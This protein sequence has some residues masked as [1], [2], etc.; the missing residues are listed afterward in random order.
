MEREVGV[1][2][3]VRTLDDLFQSPGRYLIP[4]FQRPYVWDEEHQWNLLWDDIERTAEG[5]FE[6]G[7]SP[8]PEHFLGAIVLQQQLTPPGALVARRVIDGQQRLIT[9]QLLL[10]A[11]EFALT[12]LDESVERFATRIRGLTR[13]ASAYA[14]PSQ[15]ETSLKVLPT[16]AD[17]AAFQHAMTRTELAG[18]DDTEDL[19]DIEWAHEFF[20]DQIAEWL[21]R[22]PDRITQRAAALDITLRAKLKVV[23]IDLDH[24]DDPNVIFEALNARGT[25]LLAWDLTKNH[26]L[27]AETRAGRDDER[28]YADHLKAIEEDSWWREDVR[29]GRLYVPRIDAFLFYWLVV[30]TQELVPADAVFKIFQEHARGQGTRDVAADLSRVA[31]TYKKIETTT[32]QST[33][34]QFLNRWRVLEVGVITPHLL[35]LL[36]NGV[37]DAALDRCL[38]AFESFFV[39]RMVCRVSSANLNRSLLIL[40]QE[41]EAGGP[42]SAD[43]T[44]V[45]FLSTQPTQ[46][47]VWPS[48]RQFRRALVDGRLYQQLTRNRTRLILEAIEAWMHTDKTEKSTVPS[49]LSIEHLMPQRWEAN[50][51][52]PPTSDDPEE[53]DLERRQRLVQTIGNLTLVHGKLNSAMSNAAWTS[54]GSEQSKR[55]ALTKHSTLFLNKDLLDQASHTWND[56]KIVERSDYFADIAVEI[57]P[58]PENI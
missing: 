58:P 33:L 8:A 1:D 2:A 45:D 51:P 43:D 48:D 15:P 26:L 52:P 4:I 22:E 24:D 19:T 34:G 39:R 44:I 38:L 7:G 14:D 55:D 6:A 57:W 27:H 32:D 40:L 16:V 35:W 36:S 53:S 56:D 28:L 11:A 47:A 31:G 13:N 18:D 46:L 5:V 17:R 10:D 41:L 50:W 37:S 23:A 20:H 25:P 29:Q 9:L 49:G 30:R 21:R 42:D 54:A 12:N 3:N